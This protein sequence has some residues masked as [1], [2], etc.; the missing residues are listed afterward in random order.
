MQKFSRANLATILCSSCAVAPQTGSAGASSRTTSEHPRAVVIDY[1]EEGDLSLLLFQI[2]ATGDYGIAYRNDAAPTMLVASGFVPQQIVAVVQ[3]QAGTLAVLQGHTPGC[4]LSYVITVSRGFDSIALPFGTCDVPLRFLGDQ[5]RLFGLDRTKPVPNAWWYQDGVVYGP[6][7]QGTW[8]DYPP[9][10]VSRGPYP[11]GFS[12]QEADLP[13][14]RRDGPDLTPQA[15]KLAL[16]NAQIPD[17]VA[18]MLKNKDKDLAQRAFVTFAW[19]CFKLAFLGEATIDVV[20]LQ[21]G[22]DM[23]WPAAEDVATHVVCGNPSFDAY[24]KTTIVAFALPAVHRHLGCPLS[25]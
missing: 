8:S 1:H 19:D 18:A 25:G 17:S 23:A 2:P 24:V 22:K 10:A 6:V 4:P 7:S 9:G 15:P 14:A 11:P 5:H 3:N 13:L 21:W 20:I 16:Q 12:P